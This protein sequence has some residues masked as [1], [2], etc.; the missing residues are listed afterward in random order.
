MKRICPNWGVRI[1]GDF[2]R[3]VEGTVIC[4]ANAL[5]DRC[6]HCHGAGADR[7]DRSGW[8]YGR[9]VAPLP[10]WQVF[11]VVGLGSLILAAILKHTLMRSDAPFYEL[12][13]RDNS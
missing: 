13:S 5:V 2:V 7:S 8:K 11:G 12:P 3:L 1:L 9:D 4:V 6:V 10:W